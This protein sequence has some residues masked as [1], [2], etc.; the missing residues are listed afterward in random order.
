MNPNNLNNNLHNS[1]ISFDNNYIYDWNTTWGGI[2]EDMGRNLIIDSNN[3]IYVSGDT[4]ITGNWDTFLVKYNELGIQQWNVTWGGSNVENQ[5]GIAL[6]SLNNIYITG[7][8]FTYGNGGSDIF[9]VKYNELGIQ[10]WNTTW[11]YIDWERG[12]G[13]VIDSSDDIY[14]VGRTDIDLRPGALD[15]S[16][17]LIKYDHLGREIWNVTWDD[18]KY[19]L[20]DSTFWCVTLDSEENIICVGNTYVSPN[21][22]DLLVVKFNKT[23]HDLWYARYD[24]WL[25]DVGYGVISDSSN[26]IYVTGHTGHTP[27]GGDTDA[28]IVK[29]NSSGHHQWTAIW[30]GDGLEYGNNLRFDYYEDIYLVGYTSYFG[31]GGGDAFI[32]KYNIN[33]IQLWNT[34]WGGIDYDSGRDIFFDS[35][36]NMFVLG[37]TKN[38]GEGDYEACLIKYDNLAPGLTINSPKS[39]SIFTKKEPNFNITVSDPKIEKVWYT[40]NGDQ[41]KNEISESNGTILGTLDSTVWSQL[42]YGKVILTFFTNNTDGYGVYRN[43]TIW[44]TGYPQ[45]YSNTPDFTVY[46]GTTG[47]TLSWH[48]YD[49][50]GN[51]DSYWVERN[52]TKVS[53]GSWTNDSNIL[54]LEIENLKAASYNYT[55]FVVDSYGA[56]NYSSIFVTILNTPP[57]ISNNQDDFAISIGSTDF[58]IS[59]HAIDLD[60]NNQSYWIERNTVRIAEGTWNNDTDIDFIESEI[61]DLGIYN[62][63]CFVNDTALAI[64]QSSIFVV[65]TNDIPVIFNNILNFTVNAGTTGFLIS[66]HVID[67]D[68]NNQSYW[69]ERNTVRIAEGTWNNDTDIDFI[70]FDILMIG[71][72]N[73]TCFVNDSFGLFSQSSIF[74]KI[75][76]APQYSG[77]SLP[78]INTYS[79]NTDYI[80]NCS[81]FDIDGV[82][83][84]VKLEFDY[85]NYTVF[86]N[87]NGEF[88]Y[89]FKDLTA[90]EIGY[91]FRW[92]AMDDDGIWNATEWHSFTLNKQVVQLLIYFNGTQENL[93]DLYNPIVNITIFNL[94]STPGLLKLFVDNILIQQEYTTSLTNI[95]QYLNGA[96]NIT[97][98]L[99]DQNY[100]GSTMVW[101]NIQEITPPIT[102]FDFSEDY[103]NTTIP[104]YYHNSIKINC[105]VFDSSPLHWV[106]FCEN[107]SGI[108]LNRS[109]ISL[110]NGDWVYE[111]DIS[112]LNWNDVFFFYFIANDTWGN[113]GINDNATSL[114]RVNVFD[115]QNPFSSISYILH[116]N[117]NLINISTS[118]RLTAD[119][120]GSG[121]SL[122]RYRIDDSEWIHYTQP[123]NFSNYSPGTYVISYYSVDNAGNVGEINSITV[124]LISTEESTPQVAIPSFNLGML[125]SVI[126]ITS[127]I[128]LFKYKKRKSCLFCFEVKK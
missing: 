124:V 45:I 22:N 92:H 62:Y 36:D 120:I 81:W 57:S 88:T 39:N 86:D 16:G 90:N 109:M 107:S 116:D 2:N 63:T 128:I 21:V 106:Y 56:L 15:N 115:Y 54:Y 44:K 84:E 61:L 64:N 122:I 9:L 97:A 71:M 98:V 111:I 31:A 75:N 69:I 103:L 5:R 127:I 17:V 34:T 48:V 125:I 53:E 60:G 78:A 28:Y 72:Y 101:L 104:E 1:G 91:Q 67:L 110:G 74:I 51:A 102:I 50:Y 42:P 12:N 77:I 37:N 66:W 105:S 27:Y 83:S 11:G 33:G 65:V 95:S 25:N 7:E 4:K 30:G 126:S 24:Y 108:F 100:T 13:V 117:P 87:F 114:Y 18:E 70:E 55:C 94:N 80:F 99:T 82:I 79:P 20:V 35:F 14:V 112:H 3:N 40:T 113:I 8:T 93:F 59:W 41:I 123:F 96:Y 121:I 89:I 43:V 38:Y 29:F 32:A 23:G 46:N 68:G 49:L 6:D 26:N 118:F 19:G 10:Q 119:D 73:Y 52:S 76:S 85:Q 47:Y 58:L